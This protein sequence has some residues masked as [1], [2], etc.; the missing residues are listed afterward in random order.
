M[1]KRYKGGKTL[2]VISIILIVPVIPTVSCTLAEGTYASK[3]KEIQAMVST[4]LNSDGK[5]QSLSSTKNDECCEQE[6]TSL[7]QPLYSHYSHITKRFLEKL[8]HPMFSMGFSFRIVKLV[9]AILLLFGGEILSLLMVTLS[10]M[11]LYE[12]IDFLSQ[13]PVLFILIPSLCGAIST[14]PTIIAFNQGTKFVGPLSQAILFIIYLSYLPLIIFWIR[15]LSSIPD[16][17]LVSY[18][19]AIISS[20]CNFS[21]PGVN[22]TLISLDMAL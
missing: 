8:N 4:P 7:G 1:M 3:F 15:Y 13:H 21:N 6:K 22:H 19:E 11:L 5:L 10:M 12:M 18:R 9:I 16:R 20:E 14:L 17:Y 2:I